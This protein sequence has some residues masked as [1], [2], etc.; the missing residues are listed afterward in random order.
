MTLGRGQDWGG[1]G[2]LPADG[3]VVRSD[4]EARHVVEDARRAGAEPPPL[5]LL[6]GDLG[7]AL[8]AGRDPD[9]LHRPD[10]TRVRVDLGSVTV[11]GQRR[12]FVAHLVARRRGWLA[13]PLVAVMNSEWLGAWRVAPRAHPG[14]G[15]LDLVVARLGW[16]ERLA[17]RRR[18]PSGD[19]VPHPAIVTEVITARDLEL[20]ARV[21]IHLDGERVGAAT[22]VSVRVEP[23]ALLVVV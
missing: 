4:R 21:P 3:V 23:G 2:P 11:D 12:W 1:Q 15:R 22:S 7:R 10:A 5:G 20:G 14:D 18:L 9:R 17:A 19:H 8:G 6:G 13:G 16:R